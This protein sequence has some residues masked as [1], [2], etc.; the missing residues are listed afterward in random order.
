M[1]AAAAIV[2]VKQVTKDPLELDAVPL[3]VLPA[4]GTRAEYGLGELGGRA[5][6][7]KTQDSITV[8]DAETGRPL[9]K[10]Y[11]TVDKARYPHG[12]G[13]AVAEAGGRPLLLLLHDGKLVIRDL[14]AGTNATSP[15][16]IEGISGRLFVTRD[17]SGRPLV[18]TR[19]DADLVT[20]NLETYQVTKHPFGDLVT[21]LSVGWL[22][23]RAVAA[24]TLSHGTRRVVDVATGADVFP[25]TRGSAARIGG[26]VAMAEVGDRTYL[27]AGGGDE[28]RGWVVD[29]GNAGSTEYRFH[30]MLSFDALRLGAVRGR[31]V[32]VASGTSGRIVWSLPDAKEMTVPG[33]APKLEVGDAAM[34]R[35]RF[36]VVTSEPYQARVWVLE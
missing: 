8:H 26:H 17:G 7:I 14:N 24:V 28:W 15:I 9:G 19:G 4:D 18:V 2:I 20:V 21:G 29:G 35:G 13:V 36:Y 11:G 25:A 10:P 6:F 22:D 31:G 16:P 32:A 5:V 34:V 1:V 12:D 3:A 33:I 23:R 27:V 30:R